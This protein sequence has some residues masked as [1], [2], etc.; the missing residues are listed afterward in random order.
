MKASRQLV[1]DQLLEGFFDMFPL[2]FDIVDATPE[3]Q[4][5]FFHL[6]FARNF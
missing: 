2:T 1:Q 3:I 6:T 4:M 5:R